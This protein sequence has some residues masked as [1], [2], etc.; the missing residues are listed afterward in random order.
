MGLKSENWATWLSDQEA[1]QGYESSIFQ[2]FD[3][4]SVLGDLM[5]Q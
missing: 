3:P 1:Y 5:T 4:A 2:D